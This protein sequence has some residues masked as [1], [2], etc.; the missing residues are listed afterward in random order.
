MRRVVRARALGCGRPFTVTFTL[1]GYMPFGRRLGFLRKCHCCTASELGRGFLPSAVS[2]AGL[3]R[4]R[5]GFGCCDVVVHVLKWACSADTVTVSLDRLSL[6]RAPTGFA[7][8]S[9]CSAWL[10]SVSSLAMGRLEGG[11]GPL[12]RDK[13]R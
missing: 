9:V 6:F 2:P 10:P 4:L 13:K 1:R 8:P 5:A 3:K 7:E 11:I 12:E